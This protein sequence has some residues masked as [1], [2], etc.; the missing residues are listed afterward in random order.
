[1]TDAEQ[2]RADLYKW[3]TR[4]GILTEAGLREA[5]SMTGNA[6]AIPF[7]EEH[8]EFFRMRRIMRIRADARPKG[9]VT[10]STR[11]PIAAAKIKQL[12]KAFDEAFGDDGVSLAITTAPTYKIDQSL[13]TLG[14]PVRTRKRRVTCGSSVGIGNQRNAGTLTALARK[15]GSTTTTELMGLSCNHVIGGCS[16]TMPGTPIV[17]P[18]VQDVTV[19]F[20]TLNV[21]GTFS[22]SASMRTGL[23][24]V[25]DVR[26]DDNADLACFELN[27]QGRRQLSSWHGTEE[28]GYD[29]PVEFADKP[30]PGLPV[31]KWGRSTGRTAGQVMSVLD[32][33]EPVD[34]SVVSYFGPQASQTFRGTIYYP[35]VYEVGGTGRDFSAAGDSGSLVVTV[36]TQGGTPKV[37]G[38]VIAGGPG[39]TLVLPLEPMLKQL[40]LELVTG[41]PPPRGS[42]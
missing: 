11:Q 25:L 17:V 33:P 23:P 35:T 36:E 27:Q 30:A 4:N 22:N 8:A 5:M 28:D 10:I 34:Y 9:R 24:T 3:A 20:A 13:S 14:P 42:R 31:Q 32:Q 7:T 21:V 16:T 12:T 38:V 39:K 41:Y 37:V 26:M 15:A 1:V 40:D 2:V 6:S 29:T 18:G 19:D